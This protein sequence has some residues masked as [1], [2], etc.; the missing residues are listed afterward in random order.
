MRSP[1]GKPAMTG[2]INILKLKTIA[3]ALNNFSFDIHLNAITL[4]IRSGVYL[5][6]QV[7][8]LLYLYGSWDYYHEIWHDKAQKDVF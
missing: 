6:S 3:K 1:K 8:K 5:G 7:Y 2:M 4:K